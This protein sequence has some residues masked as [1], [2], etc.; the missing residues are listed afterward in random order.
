LTIVV[1]KKLDIPTPCIEEQTAIA[2]ALSDVDAL[3]TSL[4]KLIAK[5]RAIKTAAMQQLLTGKKR[6]PPFDQTHTA[7][8][9][10]ELGE[11]PEDWEV[12]ELGE[13]SDITKLAG[14]EY[15]NYFNGYKD[16]GKII[17][18]RGTNI[19]HNVLD[20]SDVKNI[21]EATSKLLPRSKL[22]K[23]DLVFAYVGTIG[24]IYLVDEDDKFHLGPNTAKITCKKRLDN[25]YLLAYFKGPLIRSE[26]EEKI[27]VGAQP[28]LSMTKIRS[29]K[30]ISPG[31][32]EQRLIA[33]TIAGMDK[34]LNLLSRRLSKTQQ[35][36]Q[37]MM[38]EL[39]TGRTRLL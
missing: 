35:L 4:E 14:F 11:I 29:F 7:Y 23:G 20:L 38:Q 3:I 34:E 10:T 31:L 28:S 8:K 36:K 25:E 33:D 17:V 39:L 13:R 21:P 27:S 9:Q 30:I 32:E 2:N 19:T 15:S 5:K 6:L 1:L 24:P 26:I 12:F 22:F 18:L 16:G 37:G